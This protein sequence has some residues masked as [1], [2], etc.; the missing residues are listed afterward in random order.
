MDCKGPPLSGRLITQ[1]EK[2]R[3][4]QDGNVEIS[5]DQ[6]IKLPGATLVNCTNE[7]KPV[8]REKPNYGTL[9]NMEELTNSEQG[10]DVSSVNESER[11]LS[12]VSSENVC[13]QTLSCNEI[14]KKKNG[15]LLSL[16]FNLV[17][18]G[19]LENYT[20]AMVFMVSDMSEV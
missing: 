19:I 20:V 13:K 17:Q 7:A 4:L 16:V 15:Q 14:I 12:L 18:E 5:S 11:E 8:I 6:R 2:E 9:P 3:L 1:E 10:N